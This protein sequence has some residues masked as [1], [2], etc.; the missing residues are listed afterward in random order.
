MQVFRAEKLSCVTPFCIQ[1]WQINCKLWHSKNAFST[2]GV[3]ASNVLG[4]LF[5]FFFFHNTLERWLLVFSLGVM[6]PGS[7]AEKGIPDST[8]H[9]SIIQVVTVCE[10][11]FRHQTLRPFCLPYFA[12]TALLPYKFPLPLQK[13]QHSKRS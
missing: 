7:A 8:A 2:P 3:N 10:I 5:F 11:I 4:S 1:N 13:P 9:G 12:L 6:R